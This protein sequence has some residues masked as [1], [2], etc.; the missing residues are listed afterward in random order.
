MRTK[1]ENLYGK[2]DRLVKEGSYDLA[3]KVAREKEQKGLYEK[4]CDCCGR[5]K[6]LPLGDTWYCGCADE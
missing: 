5:T 6:F 3:D 4:G 1:T 2:Y